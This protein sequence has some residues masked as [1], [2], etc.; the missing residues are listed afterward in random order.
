LSSSPLLASPTRESSLLMI[1]APKCSMATPFKSWMRSWMRWN[2]LWKHCFL[3]YLF[4]P[5]TFF[6]FPSINSSN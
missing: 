6:R 5:F 2:Y 3:R 4:L 1:S